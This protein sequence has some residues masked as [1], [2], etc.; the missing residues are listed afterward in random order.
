M[1]DVFQNQGNSILIGLF[2]IN[3]HVDITE[4]YD[5][6]DILSKKNLHFLPVEN[7]G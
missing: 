6:A 2:G 3:L 1:K 7:I 4:R 5:A